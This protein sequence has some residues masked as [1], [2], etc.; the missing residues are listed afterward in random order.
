MGAAAVATTLAG[1]INRRNRRRN[2]AIH[3]GTFRLRLLRGRIRMLRLLRD[4]RRLRPI[5]NSTLDT[6][7][8]MEDLISTK[9]IRTINKCTSS[10]RSCT[11][12]SIVAMAR[13]RTLNLVSRPSPPRRLRRDRVRGRMRRRAEGRAP[14]CH[15]RLDSMSSS[16]TRQS[17]G[18]VTF[19]SVR[20]RLESG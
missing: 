11:A 20:N 14:R 4:L 2:T 12:Q 6:M 18:D 17:T 9:R 15:G 8:T 10:C 19:H 7:D 1:G 16:N 5:T 3:M 13:L